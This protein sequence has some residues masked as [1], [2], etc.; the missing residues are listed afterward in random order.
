MAIDR[1]SEQGDTALALAAMA[2]DR[3]ALRTL[4]ERHRRWIAAV[5][6]AHKPRFEDLDDLLQ[7]VA[8]AMV[9][10]IDTLR[11]P[12]HVRAWLRTVAI[13]AARAAARSGSYR[14][15]LDEHPDRHLSND[16]LDQHEALALNEEMGSMLVRLRELPA[17]YREPL[18]LRAVHGM[19][20]RVIGDMM[21]VSPAT[22]DTRVARARTMLREAN[23]PA[24]TSTPSAS[25]S[26]LG[27]DSAAVAKTAHPH[28]SHPHA[29]AT[30]SPAA[31]ASS[32]RISSARQDP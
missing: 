28:I 23:R 26:G 11:D 30:S 17:A 3:D 27:A 8:V 31:D 4:W 25:A 18:L 20:S 24:A 5:L 2:G 9:S 14:P 1:A 15:D 12:R 32:I 22:V 13:N 10:R 29:S 16:P 21:G 6:L 7:E 19:S